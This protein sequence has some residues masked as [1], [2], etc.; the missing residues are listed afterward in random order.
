MAVFLPVDWS[1]ENLGER[2][3]YF[4]LLVELA[5]SEFAS[6]EEIREDTEHGPID[7]L[8]KI[9]VAIKL[10][11]VFYILKNLKDDDMLYVSRALKCK[12]LLER[13]DIINPK[14][15]ENLLF[16]YMVMPAI[17][18]MKNWLY[19][20]LRDPVICLEFYQY[21]KDIN[22]N[23]A[24]KFLRRCNTEFV[25]TEFP[26]ILTK[27]SPHD[28]KVFGEKS[29]AFVR[30]YFDSLETNNNLVKQYLKH[31]RKYYASIKC[32]LKSNPD[33][34]LNIAETYHSCL[35]S[36]EFSPY[37]PSTT[38]YIMRN[39]KN[40]VMAKPELYIQYLLHC[41]TV[42]RYMTS[43]EC[44]EVILQMARAQYIV[45]SYK[46]VAPL[47]NRIS[48][49][50]RAA[51]KKRVFVDKDVGRF[52]E[53]WP[54]PPPA[55]PEYI[56]PDRPHV[57]NDKIYDPIQLVERIWRPNIEHI[58]TEDKCSFCVSDIEF[59]NVA[60]EFSCKDFE[61]TLHNLK[62]RVKTSMSSDKRYKMLLLLVSKSGGKPEAVRA[63]LNMALKLRNEPLRYRAAI[64]RSLVKE[65]DVWRLPQ[66]VWDALLEYAHGLGLD[67][68]KPEF[69][70]R[71][72]LHAAVIRQLL[73]TGECQ[74]PDHR[75]GHEESSSFAEYKLKQRERT[76]I[77]TNLPQIL[78]IA[79]TRESTRDAVEI[80]KQLFDVFDKYHI[81][82]K[83]SPVISIVAALAEKDAAR[84]KPL[85][86]RLYKAKIGRRELF[87]LNLTFRHNDASL[88]NVLR[89]DPSAIT[90]KDIVKLLYKGKPRL[91]QYL[92]KIM[93]YFNDNGGIAEQIRMLLKQKI[94]RNPNIKLA[95]PLA[96]LAG[97]KLNLLWRDLNG[98]GGKH[99]KL[100]KALRTFMHCARPA[101]DALT[102]G[103]RRVGMMAVAWRALRCRPAHVKQWVQTFL[104]EREIRT[105]RLALL[106]AQR[107]DSVADLFS[108]AVTICPLETLRAALFYFRHY[109]DAADL[110]VWDLIRPLML[111]VDLND[112]KGVCY[113][114]GKLD[115]VPEVIRPDYCAILYVI[116]RKVP[117]IRNVPSCDCVL[118]KLMKYMAKTRDDLLDNVMERVIKNIDKPKPVS[119]PAMVMRYLM[120]SKSDAQLETRLKIIGDVFLQK[121]A[122]FYDVNDES[123]CHKFFQD[124]LKQLMTSLHYNLAFFDTKYPY[125]LKIITWVQT[126]MQTFMPKE[127]YIDDYIKVKTTIL[128]YKAVRQ[129]VSQ[130]P[131]VF[132][133]VEKKMLEGVGIVGFTFG[134]YVAKEV[135]ELKSEYF[136]SIIEIYNKAFTSYLHGYITYNKKF[137]SAIVKGILST[138]NSSGAL[139]G[140]RIIKL[141]MIRNKDRIEIEWLIE[142]RKD[143][144]TQF[145]RYA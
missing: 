20:N 35:F 140:I 3:H 134:E 106:M 91:N 5:A 142:K 7:R 113:Y 13:R 47:F 31:Q 49:D 115:W 43:E 45:M 81:S 143:K 64:V 70:C 22:F 66:D 25:L 89:H 110:G 107:T 75:A 71:E 101:P 102:L 129:S 55:S 116:L 112:N 63:L 38:E 121:L 117:K 2:H 138:N 51:F 58:C 131:E 82:I 14:Y 12:W 144:Q 16:P 26:K 123:G 90:P 21:Y 108:V 9:D 54:Y 8:F 135:D 36:R 104:K 46:G 37:G 23:Y 141:R 133:K 96:I 56:R 122:L 32:V 103:W 109:G 6:F 4:N 127:M 99:K 80:L 67:G 92:K 50:Q 93:I 18:K 94:I 136:S 69:E 128:Y 48:P 84:A 59:K 100:A 62:K 83:S 120:L 78:T 11:D 61:H 52:V 125:C 44:Q 97:K 53:N 132:E 88:I 114:L 137:F 145:F 60:V 1:G 74:S 126:W 29:P 98:T 68:S 17:S 95:R 28:L 42:A 57:F 105:V 41:P 139:V 30:I 72:G 73:Y 77:A 27:I 111:K 79:A 130:H 124:N 85:L 40:R 76:R 34:F 15:L 118:Q 33:M 19:I 119:Y 10:K 65:T 39:R 24:V 87:H 86:Q